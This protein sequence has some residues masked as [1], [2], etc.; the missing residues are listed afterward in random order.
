MVGGR[1]GGG[2]GGGG[3]IGGR[4]GLL[5]RARIHRKRS[6]LQVERRCSHNHHFNRCVR[7]L[8]VKHNADGHSTAH[9]C[10]S[11]NAHRNGKVS[12]VAADVV[13]VVA[14]HLT[15]L[16]R[17]ALSKC[18]VRP[19]RIHNKVGPR[20][21]CRVDRVCRVVEPYLE[22]QHSNHSLGQ[23]SRV[24]DVGKKSDNRHRLAGR[25]VR[26][27]CLGST[28]QGSLDNGW[29]RHYDLTRVGGKLIGFT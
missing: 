14:D 27:G 1:R 23:I 24:V 4:G 10:A 8:V 16:G 26:D 3:A 12:I 18:N 19:T 11:S 22:R 20:V 2:R 5:T 28:G 9:A 29:C 13:V 25:R 15:Q 6:R 7:S 21:C 17:R